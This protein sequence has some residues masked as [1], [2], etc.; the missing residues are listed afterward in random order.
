MIMDTRSDETK[1][2]SLIAGVGKIEDIAARDFR[3]VMNALETKRK[4][5]K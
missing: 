5:M 2:L 4:A 3:R 1:F